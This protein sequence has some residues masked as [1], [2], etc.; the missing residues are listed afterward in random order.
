MAQNIRMGPAGSFPG[1][2]IRGGLN[3]RT[4]LPDNQHVRLFDEWG[5]A[6]FANDDMPSLYYPAPK[7]NLSAG[8]GSLPVSAGAPTYAMCQALVS[9]LA[10]TLAAD[11]LK[12]ST[13]VRRV[14]R[15][16]VSI[17]SPAATPAYNVTNQASA[18]QQLGF[19]G[20]ALVFSENVPVDI[21]LA[22]DPLIKDLSLRLGCQIAA[23]LDSTLL[24][25]YP[26]VTNTVGTGG[27]PL[28]STVINAAIADI[29]F[30]EEPI[31]IAVHPTQS[32][33]GNFQG[34]L[35]IDAFLFNYLGS[36][37]DGSV[38]SL[39]DAATQPEAWIVPTAV[40]PQTGSA[41]VTTHNL[42]FTPSSIGLIAGQWPETNDGVNAQAFSV[43]EQFAAMVWIQN[44]GSGMQTVYAAVT[45]AYGALN[46]ARMVQVKS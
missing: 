31:F 43:N 17:S 11:V 16:T 19:P 28:T 22:N 12:Q 3:I 1:T 18:N 33:F 10:T 9:R 29:G 15:Q 25:V 2:T 26:M 14:Y 27:T 40:V 5:N 24:S 30:T 44:T 34:L 13:V 23:S 36:N 6:K 46:T 45:V 41:P 38:T 7:F 37:W 39:P 4:P 42:A 32:G 35:T 20:S 8:V 21:L